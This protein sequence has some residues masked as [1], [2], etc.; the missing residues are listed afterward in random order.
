MLIN[1]FE[2]ISLWRDCTEKQKETF[3]PNISN[4]ILTIHHQ[5]LMRYRRR[6]KDYKGEREREMKPERERD[7]KEED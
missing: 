5:W 2:G 6:T 7:T 4:C 3:L 1:L